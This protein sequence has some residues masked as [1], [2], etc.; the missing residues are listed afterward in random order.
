MAHVQRSGRIG[1]DELDQHALA[2]PSTALA[3]GAALRVDARQLAR[4]R[5]RAQ[6][7][8][9]EARAG[10]F[11]ARHQRARRQCRDDRSG[12]LARL[13]PGL[14]R[15]PQRHVAGEVAMLRIAGALHHHRVG[16]GHLRQVAAA[17]ARQRRQQQL[18]EVLASKRG[19]LVT[20][21]RRASLPEALPR[22]AVSA[23]MMAV[24]YHPGAHALA[25]M[26]AHAAPQART[27]N[28]GAAR[29]AAAAGTR[30]SAPRRGRG[31]HAAGQCAGARRRRLRARH[32]P[33][34][35]LQPLHAHLPLRR[36]AAAAAASWPT[37]PRTPSSP[38]QCTIWGSCR[39]SRLPPVRSSSTV[40]MRP[41]T[42]RA[43]R[44]PPGARPTA[45]GTR[46]E[47]HDGAFALTQRQGPEAELVARGAGTDV[48]GP[49]AG[50]VCGRAR[51]TRSLAAF[52]RLK[53]KQEFTSLLVAHCA[54]KPASQRATWLEGP[55][56][57][58]QRLRPLTMR[59]RSTSPRRPLPSSLR[60]ARSD[61]HR[62]TSAPR[63]RSSAA[64]PA[65]ASARETRAA[66]C[67]RGSPPAAARDS[68][69]RASPSPPAP[70]PGGARRAAARRQLARLAQEGERGV[71]ASWPN[72]AAAASRLKGGQA[73]AA[74][75]ASAACAKPS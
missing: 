25:T 71:G 17:Q 31:R 46:C 55:V 51:W 28:P 12:Q 70:D 18:L 64:R 33:A 29:G 30:R 53:F 11:G 6:V 63:G 65:A 21:G 44:A 38:P 49:A 45:S 59:S 39:R 19:N 32:C 26:S 58:T 66:A 72:R 48:Y 13:A 14:L 4:V 3:V 34:I 52:P 35:S 40:R 2:P 37:V 47:M 8:I 9:D 69:R 67:A 10:D 57:R 62:V 23:R 56:A 43:G 7:E 68:G 36:A 60:T 50:C 15:Q 74:R 41:S 16:G 27:R 1:G 5:L 22:L 42:G 75:S 73:A 24:R 61:P 20:K 54:R